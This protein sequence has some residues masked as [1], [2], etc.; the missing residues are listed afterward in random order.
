MKDKITTAEEW[1]NFWCNKKGYV[2]IDQCDDIEECMIEFTKYHVE[3]ALKI[4]S[5]NAVTKLHNNGNRV[6]QIID[7]ESIVNAYDLENIK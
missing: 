2:S 7:T 5:C 3:K 4:A 1:F 6:L